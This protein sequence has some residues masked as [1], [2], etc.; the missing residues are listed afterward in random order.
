MNEK[1]KNIIVTVS[2]LWVVIGIFAANIILPDKE[3]SVSERRKL[4]QRPELEASDLLD[5][6]AYRDYEEYF[7]DQFVLRDQFRA[8]KAI[9]AYNLL[10]LRDNNGIYLIG[11]GIYKMEYPLDEA[12]AARAAEKFSQINAKYLS[13]CNAYYSIVPDKNYFVA[14]KNGYL[15]FDYGR[16]AGLMAEHTEDMGYIDIFGALTIEDYYRTDLHWK[17]E[18]VFPAA[19]KLLEAMGNERAVSIHS[20]NARTLYPFYG[21]YFGQAAVPLKPDTLTYLTNGTL[22]G[23]RAY[24]YDFAMEENKIK[25]IKI[26]IPVY[27]VA[28]FGGIDPY[29]LYLGGPQFIVELEN[30]SNESGRELYLFRDSFASSLAPLMLEGYSKITL[31]DLRYISAD[32]LERFISFSPGGDALFLY[33]T[34]LLN[35]SAMLR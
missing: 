16:M 20:Y 34:Q 7:L 27:D 13:E 22:E 14:Q 15:S 33:G 24:R 3:L 1:L 12:S 25:P 26:E 2:F 9:G 21:S 11:D 18:S 10:R 19:G 30:T 17:Q 29:S 5:K 35:Q 28:A 32:L 8:L 31:I 6:R 4:E 23:A